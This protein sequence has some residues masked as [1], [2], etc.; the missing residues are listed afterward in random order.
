MNF[1]VSCSIVIYNHH[2]DMID[3]VITEYQNSK[4]T[5]T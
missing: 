4:T 2:D 3:K 5:I 1:A